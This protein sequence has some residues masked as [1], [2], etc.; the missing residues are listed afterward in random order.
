[1]PLRRLLRPMMIVTAVGSLAACTAVDRAVVATENGASRILAAG[2]TAAPAPPAPDVD[3]QSLAWQKL[4]PGRPDDDVA[5][6]AIVGTDAKTGAT[7]VALKVRPGE[8][9]PVYWQE[10]PQTYTVLNGTFVA[11]GIDST[12]QPAR[13]VQGPG[14]FARV[15]A[16]MIQRLHT[17]PGAEAVMLVTVYGEWKPNFVDDEPRPT[18]VQRAAN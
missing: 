10:V 4:S 7:R 6:I 11:E 17:K 3:L 1:M 12:G 18:E 9:L 5:Q 13:I 8:T 16:R 2:S 14:T 15:P